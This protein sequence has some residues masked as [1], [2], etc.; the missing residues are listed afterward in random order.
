MT[1]WLSDYSPWNNVDYFTTIIM[2]SYDPNFKEVSPK[3]DGP[4]GLITYDDSVLE[5]MV[6]FQNLGTWY[7][8][9]I[10]VIDTL[11]RNLDWTTLRPIYQSHKCTVTLSDAGV[12]TF[13]FDNINLPAKVQDDLKSNG[14][15]TYTIKTRKAL[16]IGTT[17]KNKADIYF[18]YN[19]PITTNTTL[20]T[21]GW[22]L[23]ASTLSGS[24]QSENAFTIYPN[25]AENIVNVMLQHELK[26]E[27]TLRITDI[28]GKSMLIKT[29]SPATSLHHFKLDASNLTPGTYFV[30]LTENGVT[31]T[32]KLLIIK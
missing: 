1:N 11:D 23:S 25:P 5:Y 27:G 19:A 10:V 9:K 28:S 7:A 21:L 4:N 2:S 8:K 30:T 12:A 20:N 15:F 22:P 16:P 31:N 14:M 24:V 26:T 6:H 18:D 17:F 29:I 3:G 32:Q 13:T